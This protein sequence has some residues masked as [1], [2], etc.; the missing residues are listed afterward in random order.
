MYVN[1]ICMYT[2]YYVYKQYMDVYNILCMYT[3]YYV[4]NVNHM[5]RDERI[6]RLCPSNF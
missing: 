1:N 6:L 3:I 4:N 2:I 5:V